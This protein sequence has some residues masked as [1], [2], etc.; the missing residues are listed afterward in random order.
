[1]SGVRERFW[2]LLDEGWAAS[3]AA[4]RVGVHHATGCRWVKA[5]GLVGRPGRRPRGVSAVVTPDGR[6]PSAWARDV[7]VFELD[8]ARAK[9]VETRAKVVELVSQG[10]TIAAAARAVGLSRASAASYVRAVGIKPWSPAQRAAVRAG[11]KAAEK[12]EAARVRQMAI[13]QV[14]ALVA[15]GSTL[16][17]AASRVGV[18]VSTTRRWVRDAGVQV[19][20]G[21]RPEI[22]AQFWGLWSRGYSVGEAARRVGVH[23]STGDRWVKAVNMDCGLEYGPPGRVTPGQPVVVGETVEVIIDMDAPPG[24]RLSAQ[25]R[26]QIA[27][28]RAG[29]MTIRATAKL[30]GRPPSTISREIRRN[31]HAN[32]IYRG[33][34]AHQAAWTR[35]RRPKPSKLAQPGRLREYVDAGLK[36]RL[37]PEQ[38]AHRIELDHPDDL[39]MRVCHETIYQ[40]VYVQAR[41]GLKREIEQALRR[42]RAY[43]QPQRREGERRSRIKD[44]T[45]ID[46]R[47]AHVENRKL[48]GH[49]EGDLIIGKNGASAA[50][51]V[52]ERTSRILMVGHLKDDHTA[53]T[54]R[55]SL[56][57]SLKALPDQMR[58]SLTWDQGSEMACHLQLADDAD[59]KIYFADPHSPWQRGTNENTNGLLRQYMPKGTDLS[60]F[61][62]QDLQ[63]IADELNNRP[64]K[65]LGWLTPLEVYN[66]LL[67]HE[68]T[69]GG[70]PA[71]L[72]D[73]LKPLAQRCVDH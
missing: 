55:Q 63:A 19:G 5:A 38:I 46:Q 57:P 36:K 16:V 73:T 51:T 17:A 4:R 3:V 25:E 27:L 47:P 23:P 33:L 62:P 14:V 15:D 20:V 34:D 58:H 72:P 61:S 26:E 7:G 21:V 35:A 13:D 12:A 70:R 71:Q 45:P 10:S 44:M 54:V 65:V 6:L 48:P 56:A 42:G 69:I 66:L 49:W 30:L 8:E 1:M 68:V 43:R 29:K 60:I 11:V 9:V 39:E 18:S 31:K 28:C 59:I 64:R 2:L 40:A 37:S 41:G 53:Q 67:G 22:K 32:G 52:V 24:H 50:A